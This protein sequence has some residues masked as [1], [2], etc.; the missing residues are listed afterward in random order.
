VVYFITFKGA[1]SLNEQ[2]F[3]ECTFYK[4]IF[5]KFQAGLDL[6]PAGL[7]PEDKPCMAIGPQDL[8]R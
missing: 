5:A 8:V 1:L 2:I 4:H 3:S 7:G 6:S